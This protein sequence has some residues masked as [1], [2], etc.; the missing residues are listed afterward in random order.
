[1]DCKLRK[2]NASLQNYH[3]VFLF[4][5]QPERD[6]KIS[7]RFNGTALWIW[8][9]RYPGGTLN[10]REDN[11]K[12]LCSV[13]INPL[14]LPTYRIFAVSKSD[15]LVED[16]WE[17]VPASGCGPGEVSHPSTCTQ[18]IQLHSAAVLRIRD[19][20]P[21]SEF[22]PS[23]I[24]IKQFNNVTQKLFLSSRKYD[25]GCSPRIP[26][27]DFHP[28]WIPD[29]GVKKAPDPGSGSATLL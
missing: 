7:K 10:L 20:Y 18:Y 5:R 26:D 12:G 28:L 3:F 19:V 24:R 21:G 11:L 17:R 9:R 22:F 14:E 1:M 13:Y 6:E 23:R 16:V 29:P 25:P 8:I 27:P 2:G 15:E 4:S